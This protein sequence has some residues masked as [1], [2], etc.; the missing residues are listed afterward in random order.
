M[1]EETKMTAYQTAKR[2]ME[3]ALSSLKESMNDMNAYNIK[4]GTLKSKVGVAN[5]SYAQT[6]YAKCK[7][8]ENP[9]IA[10]IRDNFWW[11]AYKISE[12]RSSEDNH[13]IDVTVGISKRV[14][15]LEDLVKSADLP[16]GW[17][18]K[19]KELR[20]LLKARRVNAFKISSEELAKESLFFNR[21]IEDKQDGKTPDSNTQIVRLIQAILDEA[22]YV[23]NGAGKNRFKVTNHDIAFIESCITKLDAKGSTNVVMIRDHQFIRVMAG[24]F[25]H[26]LCNEAYTVSEKSYKPDEAKKDESASATAEKNEATTETA[27]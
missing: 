3:A 5:T 24:V 1:A 6:I 8:S 7:A 21:V 16:T 20:A 2:E 9:I 12:E 4:M 27:A 18:S 10:A 11:D 14:I 22:I 13:L 15:D 23:D 25:R 17:I 26:Y 19:C